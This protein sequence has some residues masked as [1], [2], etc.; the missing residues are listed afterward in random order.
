MSSGYFH[1]RLRCFQ[2]KTRLIQRRLKTTICQRRKQ[3]KRKKKTE[4]DI[5]KRDLV[6]RQFIGFI[7][8]EKVFK[9]IGSRVLSNILFH[10][11]LL[12]HSPFF[13]SSLSSLPSFDQNISYVLYI[14]LPDTLVDGDLLL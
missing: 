7:F 11:F 2:I 8:I 1:K 3:K 5:K 10:S 9:N 14:L 12:L 6:K 13:L 4:V